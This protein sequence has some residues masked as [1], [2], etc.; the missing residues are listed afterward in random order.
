MDADIYKGWSPSEEQTDFS[1]LFK[2]ENMLVGGI[3]LHEGPF[4][5]VR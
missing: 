1:C 4:V 2:E 5:P 3:L